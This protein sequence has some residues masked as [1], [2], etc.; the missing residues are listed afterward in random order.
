MDHFRTIESH[1]VI[2]NFYT[3]KVDFTSIAVKKSVRAR[4][5]T[6]RPY[7]ASLPN[8]WIKHSHPL[9]IQAM[10]TTVGYRCGGR[11][12]GSRVL[13]SDVENGIRHPLFPLRTRHFGKLMSKLRRRGGGRGGGMTFFQNLGYAAYTKVDS[14]FSFSL[15]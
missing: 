9:R 3:H 14:K 12:V 6:Q 13:G 7:L 15:E 10:V 8:A 1:I 4:G 2:Y 5:P 11:F